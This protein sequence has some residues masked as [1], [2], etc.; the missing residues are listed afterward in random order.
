[1]KTSSTR[2]SSKREVRQSRRIVPW[3]FILVGLALMAYG[4]WGFWAQNRSSNSGRTL[5]STQVANIPYP[6]V[7]RI[8]LEEA[9]RA[10]D[11]GSA[12]F[13]DVRP[14]SAYSAAHIPGA[15]NIALNELPQRLHELDPSRSIITYCT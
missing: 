13:L 7:K 4:A 3:I 14:A 6:E 15:L 10:Y 11:E 2:P 12:I 8:P 9:K 5:P 1:M